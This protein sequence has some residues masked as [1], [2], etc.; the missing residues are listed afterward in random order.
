MRKI[1]EMN[2]ALNPSGELPCFE[3]SA[4][5]GQ[6]VFETLRGITTLTLLSLKRQL[7]TAPGKAAPRAAIPAATPDAA[8]PAAATP[9]PRPAS[10]NGGRASRDVL[11]S[12]Q[13]A[14][15]R[16][17]ER[18]LVNVQVEDGQREIM[19]EVRNLQWDLSDSGAVDELGVRLNIAVNG[20]G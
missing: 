18:L 13:E 15:F 2:R 8:E 11:L 6:G 19:H 7:E 1:E 10:G 17:A 16:R 20:K 3:A 14:D 4:L 12:L 9:H 5:T